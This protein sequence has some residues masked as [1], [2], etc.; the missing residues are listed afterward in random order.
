MNDLKDQVAKDLVEILSSVIDAIFDAIASIRRPSPQVITRA[1]LYAFVIEAIAFIFKLLNLRVFIDISEASLALLI[2]VILNFISTIQRGKV[3]K[4]FNKFK[5][6]SDTEN[7]EQSIVSSD[8][9][10]RP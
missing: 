3:T 4:I 8:S 1:M 2:L 6:R 7:G 5:E 9:D 10:E